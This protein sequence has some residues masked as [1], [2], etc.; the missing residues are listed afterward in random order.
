MSTV[1]GRAKT[2]APSSRR[3]R[4]WW[5]W[6]T[7]H[8]TPR[9]KDRFHAQPH[10]LRGALREAGRL[11]QYPI[12]RLVARPRSAAALDMA[13]AAVHVT[14]G[15][16]TVDFNPESRSST[17]ICWRTT[18]RASSARCSWRT[19]DTRCSRLRTRRCPERRA[20]AQRRVDRRLWR[21]LLRLFRFR[22]DHVPSREGGQTL[23]Q[24]LEEPKKESTAPKTNDVKVSTQA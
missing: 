19:S 20:P 18:R 7:P 16:K 13:S 6:S 8:G 4:T 23:F 5:W 1:R 21:A 17:P 14:T 12:Q 2:S 3:T 11:H 10:R 9:S 22:P 15:D 24:N